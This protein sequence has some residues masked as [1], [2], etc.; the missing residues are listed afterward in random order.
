MQACRWAGSLRD[1]V[2]AEIVA[3]RERMAH[4]EGFREAIGIRAAWRGEE[5]TSAESRPS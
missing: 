4:L 2:R 1:E 5:S 3:L